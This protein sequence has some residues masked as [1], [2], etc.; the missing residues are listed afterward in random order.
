M[1]TFIQLDSYSQDTIH[2]M[3]EK[4]ALYYK[5]VFDE[6]E[7]KTGIKNDMAM[8]NYINLPNILNKNESIDD[9]LQEKI[10][11]LKTGD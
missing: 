4:M 1:E 2:F 9:S 5:N 6:I 3:D 11:T 8:S 10:S 7:K